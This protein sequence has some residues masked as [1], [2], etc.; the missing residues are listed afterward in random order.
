MPH[1]ETVTCALCG[2]FRLATSGAYRYTFKRYGQ[3][4]TGD[5]YRPRLSLPELKNLPDGKSAVC[6]DRK[7]CKERQ[8]WKRKLAQHKAELAITKSLGT[9]LTGPK[10]KGRRTTR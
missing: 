5:W 2:F 9:R 8:Y 1:K 10:P 4:A 6:R 7:G 3:L